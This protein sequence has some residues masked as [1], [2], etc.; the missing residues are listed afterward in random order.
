MIGH[1]PRLEGYTGA[2]LSEVVQELTSQAFQE[3]YNYET[4]SFIQPLDRRLH[5]RHFHASMVKTME[6]SGRF[7]SER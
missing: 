3:Q 6:K 7:V 5:L 4:K 2:D 1:D